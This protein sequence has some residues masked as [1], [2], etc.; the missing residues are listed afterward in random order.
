M[1]DWFTA[2]KQ[3]HLKRRLQ[4]IVQVASVVL[5]TSNLWAGSVFAK[6]PFRTANPR[7]IGDKTEAAFRAL[8]E[9]GDYKAAETQLAQAEPNEPLAYALRSLVAFTKLDGEKDKD[10]KSAI[11]AQI[12][13]DAA[14]TRETAQQIL[15]SDPLRGNLYLAVGEFLDGAYV[16]A[17]EGTVKGIPHALSKLQTVT[18]YLETAETQSPN[19]PE[20][21]LVKGFMDLYAGLN[22]PFS[23]TKKAMERLDKYAGPRYL[24]DWG[25]ALGYRELD[26]YDQAMTAVDRA[27]QQAPSNPDFLYLKAQLLAKKGNYQEA[28]NYLNKALTKQDQLP[29]STVKQMKRDLSRAQK[30]LNGTATT[31]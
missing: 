18:N 9:Q 1:A 26:Q 17:K 24:A 10:K 2:S 3:S 13:S 25:L 11:L 28:T 8:F 29:K 7:A 15:S 31:K 22:L 30:R 23:D 21:N 12:Q 27:L 14:K 19:D 20:L 16:F 4:S 5:I 6:D